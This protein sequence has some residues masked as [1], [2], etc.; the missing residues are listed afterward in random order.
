MLN[1][2]PI[3]VLPAF[4]AAKTLKATVRELPQVVDEC[5]LVDDALSPAAAS[6]DGRDGRN[7][8]PL[9]ACGGN[10]VISV[11]IIDPFAKQRVI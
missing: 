5:I 2:R 6:T 10:A 11:P 3:V 7:V 8:V 1:G 4:N 9:S